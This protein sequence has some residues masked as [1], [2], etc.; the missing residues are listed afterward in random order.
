MVL[1]ERQFSYSLL[2][3][4]KTVKKKKKVLTLFFIAFY[5]I[6]FMMQKHFHFRRDAKLVIIHPGCCNHTGASE[7][8]KR[9]IGK[10]CNIML[11]E[12]TLKHQT[13]ILNQEVT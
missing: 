2:L 8:L 12:N 1:T 9:Q 5:F 7:T 6:K 11:C 4:A 10:L 3:T 13:E